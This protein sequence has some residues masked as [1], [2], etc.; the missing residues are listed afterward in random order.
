[1]YPAPKGRGRNVLMDTEMCPW[2]NVFM[3]TLDGIVGTLVP[4]WKSRQILSFQVTETFSIIAV[5]DNIDI[6]NKSKKC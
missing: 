4:Y 3:D 1:M 2:T 5:A 6:L